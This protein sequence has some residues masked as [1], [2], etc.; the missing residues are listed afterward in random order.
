MKPSFRT[1]AIGGLLGSLAVFGFF[2]LI[3]PFGIVKKAPWVAMWHALIGGEGW[4]L[5][6]IVGGLLFIGIGVLWALP[7]RFVEEPS[8]FKGAVLGVVPTLWAWTAM[9]IMMG[10]MPLGGLDPIK[11]GLP[12]IANCFIWGPILGWYA[13]EKLINSSRGGSVYF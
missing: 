6:A 5:P 11:V 2:A 1:V 9:P 10:E 3:T 13:R 7:F 4:I 8:P 12:V